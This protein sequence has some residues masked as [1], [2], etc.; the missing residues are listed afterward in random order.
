MRPELSPL[1]F[2]TDLAPPT[3]KFYLVIKVGAQRINGS[4]LIAWFETGLSCFLSF[5]YVLLAT[6]HLRTVLGAMWGE[7]GTNGIMADSDDF[8]DDSPDKL[9]LTVLWLSIYISFFCQNC[10]HVAWP[11]AVKG[12]YHSTVLIAEENM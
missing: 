3:L 1:F 5:A 4:A 7:A 11:R 6:M 8:K 12:E 9:V 2:Q 10:L